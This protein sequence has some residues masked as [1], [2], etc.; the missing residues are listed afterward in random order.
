MA[1]IGSGALGLLTIAALRALNEPTGPLIATAKYAEQRQWAKELGADVVCEPGELERVVRSTTRS[2][3]LGNKQLTGGIDAV[4]DC[5]GSEASIAQAVRVCAPGGTVHLV[6]MPGVT[7]VD[8]TPVW[9]REVALRGT[10]AYEVPVPGSDAAAD[11]GDDFHTAI[12]LVRRLDLG[13]LVSATYPLSRYEDAIAH[14]ATAGARG[15]VK[16]AFDL[17]GER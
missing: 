10:Y 7:S 17:R 15:A 16:V 5:V 12:D 11:A 8:L 9:Q 6:G 14:A 3:V 2:H 4:V 1:V 13:R